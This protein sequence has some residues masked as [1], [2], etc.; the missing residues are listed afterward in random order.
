M[1]TTYEGIEMYAAS[2][3]DALP[4][5]SSDDI[6]RCVNSSDRL[7]KDAERASLPTRVALLELSLEELGK[8]ATL[9]LLLLT[10]R[11]L[12]WLD[13]P[14]QSFRSDAARLYRNVISPKFR[15]ELSPLLDPV[16]SP[17]FLG[18]VQAAFR[19]HRVKLEY[20]DRLNRLIATVMSAFQE[21]PEFMHLA[22]KEYER[23][24]GRWR[25]LLY[26][27]L[28]RRGGKRLAKLHREAVIPDEGEL[29]RLKNEGLYVGLGTNRCLEPR[30]RSSDA[31]AL[32]KLIGTTRV[33]VAAMAVLLGLPNLLPE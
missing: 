12:P 31:K 25:T 8:G 19:E 21:H 17:K 15:E 24:R 22:M 26:G 4:W 30:G 20:V 7:S 16:L 23:I 10:K 6:V 29:I 9:G 32:R 27:E 1:I 13:R 3:R 11:V 33:S 2:I 18:D 5:I 28:M 14:E